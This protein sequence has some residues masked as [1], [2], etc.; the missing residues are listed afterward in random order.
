MFAATPP[1]A[2]SALVREGALDGLRI[3][4]PDGLADPRGYLRGL[5]RRPAAAGSWSRR[6]SRARRR[7]PATGRAPAP[8]ATTRCAGSA[9]CSSTR[10]GATALTGALPPSS[11]AARGGLRRGGRPRRS[12]MS[13]DHELYAEVH[14]LVELV[15]DICHDDVRLRDHTRRGLE[16]AL[17][18]LLVAF[19]VYRAYVVPG[20]PAP[21][22]AR[23]DR[24]AG[25]RGG[26][27][28][29]AARGPAR[30][31]GPRRATWRWAGS[32]ATARRDEFVVRFQQ[33]CGPVDGQ[34][35][36]GHRVLPLVPR[37]R[38]LN[39][40]GGDPARFGVPP[41]EF[42][43]CCRASAARWPLTM[44]T[45]STHDTKRAEDVRARLAVLSELPDGVARR[46]RRAWRRGSPR[47][48]RG[49]GGPG[50]RH[51]VPALADPGRRLARRTPTRLAGY[52]EKAVREA[53]VHTT[54]TSRTRTTRRRSRVRPG[55]AGRRPGSARRVDGVR[56]RGSRP[57]ARV[58]VLARSWCS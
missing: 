23:A 45:L 42:H 40:V 10:P 46:G 15:A 30:H 57:H 16:E 5:P 6:S 26:Q 53:K 14:R 55:G 4:H 56:R 27:R 2:R 44:T 47:P 17:V 21:G 32:G 37:W 49:D 9:G 38:A 51:R 58:N 43:A 12:G 39:E 48:H 36:R 52:L 50:R 24:R 31:R 20:E 41:D 34:G 8:P 22:G 25:R 18:E 7:C 1:P 35:R 13:I 28:S 3:D 54:W 19:D 33:T 29:A 11:P